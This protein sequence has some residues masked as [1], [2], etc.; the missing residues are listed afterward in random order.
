M[1]ESRYRRGDKTHPL[2]DDQRAESSGGIVEKLERSEFTPAGEVANERLI[3]A[4]L[5]PSRYPEG[6]TFLAA[7]QDGFDTALAE[8]LTEDR[9]LVIV[10]P[11]GREIVSAP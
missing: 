10:Y 6:A 11:D 5:D 4:M 8:A 2:T 3:E 9:P 7:D 1:G